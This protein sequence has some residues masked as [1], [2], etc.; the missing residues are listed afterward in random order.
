MFLY[1]AKIRV[2]NVKMIISQ[3]NRTPK[4]NVA[5]VASR[6]DAASDLTEPRFK[7][8]PPP[9]IVMSEQLS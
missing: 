9:P 3:G 4:K 2:K 6:A 5:A 1:Q 8:R 7:P